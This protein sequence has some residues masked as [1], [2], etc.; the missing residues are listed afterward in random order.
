MIESSSRGITEAQ[1]KCSRGEA[2]SAGAAKAFQ[3]PEFGGN[4]RGCK[5]REAMFAFANRREEQAPFTLPTVEFQGERL[6][7]GQNRKKQLSL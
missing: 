3:A 2:R 6:E 4:A 5:Y 1:A 7:I